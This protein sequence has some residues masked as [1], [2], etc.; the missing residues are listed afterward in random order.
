MSTYD[1][2]VEIYRAIDYKE[3]ECKSKP[4]YLFYVPENPDEYGVRLCSMSI[5]RMDCPFKEYPTFCWE[6]LG[7]DLPF[8][9]P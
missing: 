9:G 7:V 3:K 2:Y 8:I 5:L 4:G 1:A 6:L